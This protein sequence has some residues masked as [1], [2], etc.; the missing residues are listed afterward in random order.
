MTPNVVVDIGNSRMKW[1]WCVFG[2][3]VTANSSL[4]TADTGNWNWHA[5]Q[6]PIEGQISWV[7]SSVNPPAL[8]QFTDWALGRGDKVLVLDSHHQLPIRIAVDEPAKVGMDRLLAG[9]AASYR[10]PPA[11]AGIVIDVGTAMTVDLVDRGGFRGGA[12]LPGFRLM[13][14]S[15]HEHTAKLPL[16]GEAEVFEQYPE[17]DP[18][19]PGK[20]T[21]DAIAAGVLAAVR[22]AAEVLVREL[23]TNPSRPTTVI[24]TG[25]GGRH[26]YD[27]KPSLP[28]GVQAQ[29]DE[30]LVLDGIRIAAEALP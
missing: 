12:I 5:E 13:F 8:A 28:P 22:G 17:I 11:G 30:N 2:E 9:V 24:F 19:P 6:F 15:L 3:P 25:G 29:C 20:N 23:V 10:L 4:N 21:T 14:Q 7:V 16:V 18:T 27:M 1:G 26:L